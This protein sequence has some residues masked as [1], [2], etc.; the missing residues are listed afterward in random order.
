MQY[1]IADL[2]GDLAQKEKQINELKQNGLIGENGERIRNW[3]GLAEEANKERERLTHEL[4]EER[5]EN[6]KQRRKVEFW[7]RER[8][9]GV[10]EVQRV[11]E[12]YERRLEEQQRTDNE[13]IT[14]G[15]DELKNIKDEKTLFKDR[16]NEQ[17]MYLFFCEILIKIANMRNL[18]IH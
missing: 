13:K 18:R 9:S 3:Q 7:G 10:E 2:R 4:K 12:F 5:Q 11:R 17:L 8:K 16:M 6:E 15:Q 14:M 1:Q